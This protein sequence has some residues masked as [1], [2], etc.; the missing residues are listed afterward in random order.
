MSRNGINDSYGQNIRDL[1]PPVI[2]WLNVAGVVDI[3][4]ARIFESKFRTQTLP[5]PRTYIVRKD[6]SP[7]DSAATQI[8]E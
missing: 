1:S 2:V 5:S 6:V 3:C 7:I 8:Y 4:R